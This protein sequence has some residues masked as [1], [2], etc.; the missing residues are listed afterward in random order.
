MQLDVAAGSP[1]DPGEGIRTGVRPHR[2][3]EIT[4][5]GSV[6]VTLAACSSST[7]GCPSLRRD[8]VSSRTR[9]KK[10]LAVQYA[11]TYFTLEFSV[12]NI[13]R[14]KMWSYITYIEEGLVEK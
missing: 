9:K 4:G 1:E 8:V 14:T 10:A 13:W 7:I 3:S 5:V 12:K 11:D 6:S 2:G